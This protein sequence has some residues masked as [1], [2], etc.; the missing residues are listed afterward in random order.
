MQ[1]DIPTRPELGGVVVG[2]DGSHGA[3]EAVLWAA[4]E[5]DR[6]GRPLTLV[7]A[8]DT[9]RRALFSTAETLQ[10]VREAGHDLLVEA[11]SAVRERFPDLAMTT[12][13]SRMEPLAGLRAAAAH[14][15]TVVVGSRGL[16]GFSALLLGSVGLGVVARAEVPVVVVRGEAD[17]PGTGTVTAAVHG[18]ADLD[19]LLLAA[20]EAE[21]RKA[22]LRML[23]VWNVLGHVG[24][25]ATMLDDLDD[26]ARERVQELK[27]L[28]DQVQG[29]YPEL[30]VSPHV[31]TGTS[32]PGA[33]VEA[34]AHAD[35]L[36]MGSHRR[37]LP[38][39]RP[40]LGRVAH[41]V[42][43]H[44]HC[45]VEVVPPAF[46]EERQRHARHAHTD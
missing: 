13:L 9:D 24:D 28:A 10:S 5:A 25:V 11:A 21:A 30:T 12:E 43:H 8:A 20:A 41:S 2:V 27:D 19:W 29:V 18:A 35:L 46:A 32:V 37:K 7:H 15:A 40:S 1:S 45:P 33:L 36:V 34:S 38:V 14:R 6:R 16:G 42:L 17:R 44:A 31:D 26:V 3:R 22:S 39:G 23:A 4:A